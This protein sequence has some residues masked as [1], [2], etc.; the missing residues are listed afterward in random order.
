LANVRKSLSDL[1]S[2][3]QLLKSKHDVE[4]VEGLQKKAR[5]RAV[6]LLDQEKRLLERLNEFSDRFHEE[7]AFML[8][9][10]FE[11]TMWADF[12]G[13]LDQA[14]YAIQEVRDWLDKKC[15]IDNHFGKDE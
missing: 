1:A 15:A 5:A 12:K 9:R 8:N 14:N 11:S 7:L 3:F 6:A 2:D 13:H 4:G 10:V